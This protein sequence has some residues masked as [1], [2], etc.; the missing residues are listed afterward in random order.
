MSHEN[1]VTFKKDGRWYN[2]ASVGTAKRLLGSKK[3]YATMGEAVCYA[4]KRSSNSKVPR[5]KPSIRTMTPL[6]KRTK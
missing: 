2:R 6:G 4:K 5:R 1:S 3:G